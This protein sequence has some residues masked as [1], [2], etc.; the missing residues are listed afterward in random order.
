MTEDEKPTTDEL[1]QK[2][3]VALRAFIPNPLA[4][5]PRLV[6]QNQHPTKMARARA[7]A[8]AGLLAAATAVGLTPTEPRQSPAVAWRGLRPQ[9]ASMWGGGRNCGSVRPAA[10]ATVPTNCPEEPDPRQLEL[11]SDGARAR[12]HGYQ[13]SFVFCGF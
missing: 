4:L 3:D 5:S 1:F 12:H 10:N 2:H 9:P 11:F 8:D 7:H 13:R 6:G